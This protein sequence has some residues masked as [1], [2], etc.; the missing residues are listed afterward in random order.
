MESLRASE[1]EG[2]LQIHFNNREPGENGILCGEVQLPRPV[3][4]SW[5]FGVVEELASV[6]G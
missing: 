4:T 5:D 1:T 6:M 2:L 3:R